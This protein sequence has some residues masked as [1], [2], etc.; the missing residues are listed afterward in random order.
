[1]TAP[2]YPAVKYENMLFWYSDIILLIINAA[3]FYITYGNF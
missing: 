1:V 3:E 2:P